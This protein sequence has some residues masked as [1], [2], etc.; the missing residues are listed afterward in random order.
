MT[1]P[2]HVQCRNGQPQA[3]MQPALDILEFGWNQR[4]AEHLVMKSRGIAEKIFCKMSHSSF[5][6][7]EWGNFLSLLNRRMLFLW[8][9]DEWRVLPLNNRLAVL[10]GQFHAFLCC[11]VFVFVLRQAITKLFRLALNLKS[12]FLVLLRSWGYRHG[13]LHLAVLGS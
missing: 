10:G 6:G 8:K 3:S 4:H 2:T 11:S 9:W 7:T 1:L 13:T 5:P 12:S